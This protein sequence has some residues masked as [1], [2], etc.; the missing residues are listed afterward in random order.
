M[1]KSKRDKTVSLTQVKKK[2]KAHKT[3]LFTKVQ[4][5]SDQFPTILVFSFQNLITLELQKLREEMSD[6]K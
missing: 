5:Y 2:G 1:V 3:E 6:S 4:T